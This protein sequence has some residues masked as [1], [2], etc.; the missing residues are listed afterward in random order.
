[1]T[2]LIFN[3]KEHTLQIDSDYPHVKGT[4]TEV[5]TIQLSQQH[6][7]FYEVFQEDNAG[8]K[9]PI[10]RFPISDTIIKYIHS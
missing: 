9:V 8:K 4:Y 5:M 10:F 7:N 2:I 6:Y 1:M 3:T